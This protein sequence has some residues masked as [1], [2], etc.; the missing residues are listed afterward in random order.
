M[1]ILFSDLIQE[2]DA[3]QALKTPA[4]SDTLNLTYPL[5]INFPEPV[6][7]SAV[8]IGNT[9]GRFFDFAF[10][11]TDDRGILSTQAGENIITDS[12]F[13]LG[14]TSTVET[15]INIIY[16]GAGLYP[17]GVNLSVKK[18]IITSDASFI[19]RLGA[20]R[21]VKICTSV[22]KQPGWNSTSEPRITLSGQIVPGA[23]GYN[24]RTLSLDSR[25]KMGPEAIREIIDGYKEI[26][27][28]YPFFIDL[29]TESY[30]LPYSKLYATENNQREWVMEGGIMQFL[31]S[32]RY[33]FRE[34]F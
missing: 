11:G 23:G 27:L 20:G 24:Y 8:G 5:V 6:E 28:G 26:G 19:G 4:L 21:G 34:A 2:S 16:E 7:I 18:I 25:Y 13:A 1:I 22:A 12:G 10:I 31:Y 30:K 32:Y 33:Q 15:A 17:L 3:A 29:T 9:D 14:V